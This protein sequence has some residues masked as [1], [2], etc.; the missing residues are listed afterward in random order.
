M[1]VPGF[2]L[3]HAKPEDGADIVDFANETAGET[4]FFSFGRNQ[5]SHSARSKSDEIRDLKVTSGI[6]LVLREEVEEGKGVLVGWAETHFKDQ[7][8]SSHVAW[9]SVVVRKA[10]WRRGL[11]KWLFAELMREAEVS[12]KAEKVILCV[13]ATYTGALKMYEEGFGFEREGV[14]TGETKIDGVYY[15]LVN[16]GKWLKKRV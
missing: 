13:N 14:L 9:A 7:R 3:S 10:F 2:V 15:D 11:G 1:E 16:L 6:I 12:L 4:N 5:F 8:R